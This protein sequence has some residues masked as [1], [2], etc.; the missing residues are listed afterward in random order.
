MYYNAI[1]IVFACKTICYY[2]AIFCL[3]CFYHLDHSFI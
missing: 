1:K 2:N 3:Q